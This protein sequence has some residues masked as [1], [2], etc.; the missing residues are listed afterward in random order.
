MSIFTIFD[1]GLPDW[2]L[3]NDDG[4]WCSF[5]G[6]ILVVP[7]HVDEDTVCPD[8]CRTCGAPDDG[9]AMREYFT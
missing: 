3:V 4:I 2:A 9:E 7:W 1:V 5:C 6:E 8:E